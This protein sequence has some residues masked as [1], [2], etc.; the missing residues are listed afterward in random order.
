MAVG[1]RM[2]Q[3]RGLESEWVASNYI[4]AAGEI[5]LTLDTGIAKFG[6]GVNGWNSLPIAFENLYLPILGKASDSELLD[7]VGIESLVKFADT[8][9]NPTADSFVKRTGTGRIKASAG[10]ASDDVA[11]FGQLDVSRYMLTSRTLTGAGT[12]A[13]TDSFSSVYVNNASNTT[14]IQVTIPPNVDVAFPVGTVIHIVAWNIGGAKLIAGAGV[15][16]N[17]SPYV[18]PKY[19][20]VR[21]VKV[22]TNTWD[23]FSL[24]TGKILPSFKIR[25]TVA[26]DSYASAYAFV[27]YDTVDTSETYNPDN[28]WFSIPGTGMATARRIIIN[29]DGYYA[30][31]VNFATNGAG[32][33][34]FCQART[35][36]ADNSFTGS[37][38]MGV[39][40]C[41]AVCSF[42]V[43]KRLTAGQSVGVA[44]GFASGNQGKADGEASGGDPHNLKI[45][46]L[47]D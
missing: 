31:N 27:P 43:E 40:P 1:T 16:L 4:L 46:R 8:D 42:T 18:M 45:V 14:H 34:T 20:A 9:V 30:I 2:Q 38:I 19:G 21:L 24:N 33:V 7:G 41:T 44:N 6:D 28:E 3:R 47:S 22:A 12:L 10:A 23:S 32:G 39:Q 29:K 11:T 17:G 36:T 37:T 25:R 5:G 13:L 35:L 15:T 26:G